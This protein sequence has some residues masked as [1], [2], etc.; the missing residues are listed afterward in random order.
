MNTWTLDTDNDTITNRTSFR[1]RRASG[2]V[3]VTQDVLSVANPEFKP[4]KMS[5]AS[6]VPKD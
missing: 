5:C 4:M 6:F 2:E 1:G 3:P